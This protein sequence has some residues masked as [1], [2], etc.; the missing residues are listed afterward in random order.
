MDDNHFLEFLTLEQ[1]ENIDTSKLNNDKFKLLVNGFY[2]K[3]KDIH[4]WNL[5]RW[6]VLH[7]TD[8]SKLF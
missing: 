3:H 5:T 7:I 4:K 6:N 8:M 1:F 2:E